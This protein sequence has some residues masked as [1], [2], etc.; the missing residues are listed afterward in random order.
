MPLY[1]YQC[2]DCGNLITI[3]RSFSDNSEPSCSTCGGERMTRIYSPL[4]QVKSK[5][6][7][8]RDLSWVDKNLASRIKKKAS[9]KLNPGLKDAVDRMD[10]K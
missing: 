6:D 2:Q 10:S 7:R 3:Q 4:S 5:K 8:I 9:Q 1:D